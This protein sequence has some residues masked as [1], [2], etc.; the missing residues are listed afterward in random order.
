MGWEV[1]IADVADVA[2]GLF[3]GELVEGGGVQV[4]EHAADL[5]LEMVDILFC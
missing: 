5:A 3:L 2:L 1:V 4:G